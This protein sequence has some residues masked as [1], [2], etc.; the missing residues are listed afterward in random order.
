MSAGANRE[1]SASHHRSAPRACRLI[2]VKGF[3]QALQQFYFLSILLV[4][5]L[6][7]LLRAV[8]PLLHAV[9]I[10]KDQLQIN[11]LDIAD[12][13]HFTV[14]VGNVLVFKARTT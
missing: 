13:V 9:E 4:A 3:L 12:R 2:V 11:R 5:A 1:Q 14:N 7:V 10:R 6:H 8:N